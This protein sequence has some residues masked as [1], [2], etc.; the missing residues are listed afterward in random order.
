MGI[1]S[2]KSAILY[3]VNIVNSNHKDPHV[4]ALL[5]MTSVSSRA[6]AGSRAIDEAA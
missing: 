4:A 5:R 6:T 1:E 3:S 2:L